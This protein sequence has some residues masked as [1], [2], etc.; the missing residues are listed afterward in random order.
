MPESTY[1][2]NINIPE[3]SL[4]TDIKV[5]DYK[6]KITYE[7]LGYKSYNA[8]LESAYMEEMEKLFLQ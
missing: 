2:I 7:E 3:D 5:T 1:D 8:S 6:D 4:I